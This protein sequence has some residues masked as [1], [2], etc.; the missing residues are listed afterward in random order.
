MEKKQYKEGEECGGGVGGGG[1]E[2][3]A[4]GEEGEGEGEREDEEEKVKMEPSRF[5][6]SWNKEL[7]LYMPRS[8]Q[9]TPCYTVVIYRRQGKGRR[10]CLGD[11]IYYIPCRAS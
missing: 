4:G 6:T 5:L 3:G 10:C 1:E 7:D 2:G 11:R 8:G 9:P